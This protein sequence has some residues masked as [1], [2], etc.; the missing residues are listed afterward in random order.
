YC[1]RG[2]PTE[3]PSSVV[4]KIALIQRGNYK[5]TEKAQFAKTA[6]A[7]GAVI[8]NNVAGTVV[9]DFTTL[10]SAASIVPTVMISQADGEALRA[11]P[12]AKVSVSFGKL[13][14]QLL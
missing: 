8:Y 5:F 14:Y 11:T 6:G 4:G 12:N 9:P 10:P 7:I 1:G 2:G 3:Y 13:S